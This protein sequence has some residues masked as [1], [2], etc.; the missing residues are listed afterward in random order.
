MFDNV[1]WID[2]INPWSFSNLKNSLDNFYIYFLVIILVFC[3]T[4]RLKTLYSFEP[5]I[6][7]NEKDGVLF[8]T[9]NIEFTQIIFIFQ[10]ILW[11]TQAFFTHTIC[12]GC[13]GIFLHIPYPSLEFFAQKIHKIYKTKLKKWQWEKK[14]CT[15]A[16]LLMCETI[17]EQWVQVVIWV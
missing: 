15:I 11:W 14:V 9:R 7:W 8:N 13:I 4:S 16:S 17:L 10:F 12:N 1:I 5:L 3:L 6:F 2:N